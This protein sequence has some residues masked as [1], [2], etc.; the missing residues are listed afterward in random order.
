MFRPTVWC[1]YWIDGPTTL[2]RTTM[3]LMYIILGFTALAG[4]AIAKDDMSS[5]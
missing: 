5:L 4:I 2:G 3:L 1:G